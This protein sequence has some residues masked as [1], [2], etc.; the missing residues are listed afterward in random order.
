MTTI[1]LLTW[2]AAG[3]SLGNHTWDHP[4]L[5]RCEP[6]EQRRQVAQAH[7]WITGKFDPDHLLFAYPNGNRTAL[8]E[9]VLRE[10][11]Y[12]GAVLFD[13]R[14]SNLSEPLRISRLRSNADGNLARFRATLSGVHPALHALRAKS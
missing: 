10:L 7:E 11:G 12:R 9:R 1:E 13:H 14:L 6:D 4:L 5:D 2:V 8:S 3:H